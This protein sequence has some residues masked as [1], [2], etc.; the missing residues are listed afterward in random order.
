LKLFTYYF[1]LILFFFSASLSAQ[2]L[3]QPISAA[4]LGLGAYSTL[5]TDVF[6]FVNNQ[7][8]LAQID[9]VTAGVHGERRFLLNET[10]LYT[11]AL[12]VP[13]TLGNFG[14]SV[15]YFGFKNFNESQVGLAYGRSLGKKVD[16]GIQFNYYGYRVPSY[17]SDNTVNFEI[18]AI[19]HLTDK[20][21][22]GVH[23]YSPVGGKFSKTDEKLTS[24]YSFGLGY[25]ASEHF[26][27]SAE[28]MKEEGI[29][30]NMNAGVQ[31]R[32]SK[33]FFARAGIASATSTSY[34][35]VGLAWNNLR[36]DITGSYHPQLGLSPG[37]LLI[38]NMGKKE[39]AATTT[40]DN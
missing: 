33:Q 11:A 28:V 14:V 25:D 13:S 10:S 16:I 6:S 17:N 27:V 35:G 18:G 31:Y 12:A 3:R 15:K 30:V 40:N 1:Y 4:Y 22:A 7:A 21:N 5:H 36:L 29:P 39:T 9:R 20:L 2:T 37:L 38:I 8:A 26:F 34:A 32:F 19:M 23:V 24:V